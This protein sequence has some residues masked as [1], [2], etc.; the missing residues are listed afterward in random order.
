M[1]Q[2]T[3]P[4]WSIG[5]ADTL[6]ALDA[7]ANGLTGAEAAARLRRFGP[8]TIAAKHRRST[9]ALLAVQFRSPIILILV[10][11][12]LL[13]AFLGDRPDAA[14]IL[15]IVLVSGLLTFFQERGASSAVERL[16]EVVKVKAQVV[17]DGEEI[18][19]SHEDVVPGDVVVL[20]AGVTVPADCL[21]LES[22]DLFVDEAALTGESFP[23]EKSVGVLPA[24]TPLARRTNSVFMGTHAIS[25]T[26]RALVVNTGCAT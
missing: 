24:D 22:T 17:R 16:L 15:A 12:A 21:L 20:S 26:A 11:A 5:S 8:N 19:V 13:S 18:S 4:F 25:G 6:S 2:G 1:A 7:T 3:S 10:A 14:I 23:V 9:L